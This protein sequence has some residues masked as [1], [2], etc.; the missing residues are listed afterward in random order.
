[1]NNERTKTW[2]NWIKRY[3]LEEFFLSKGMVSH[4]TSKRIQRQCPINLLLTSSTPEWT[5]VMTGKFYEYL[6]AQN[7]ILVLINGTQDIEFETVMADLDA[8][9]LA[10]NDRSY[11]DVYDF[12]I[13]KF[14]EWQ[15]T[16]RV[17]QTIRKDKLR[18]MT[19]DSR[20]Q[21]FVKNVLEKQAI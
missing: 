11:Q 17:K 3:N 21:K 18:D 4:E 14:T 10:Y 16:G 13:E 20:V 2:G 6:A 8:G 7:P 9:L 15:L 5:G 19:W 12:I 1:M